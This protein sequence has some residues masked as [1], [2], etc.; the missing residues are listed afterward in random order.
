MKE[1]SRIKIEPKELNYLQRLT[2]EV[3]ART[4]II[5]TLLENHAVDNDDAVLSSPAFKTYHDQLS[6]LSAEFELA[7]SAFAEKNLPNEYKGNST[8]HW[9]VDFATG[10]LVVEA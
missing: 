5:T 3:N 9:R 1:L 4:N 8:A 10:E 2:Y 7:K 6:A